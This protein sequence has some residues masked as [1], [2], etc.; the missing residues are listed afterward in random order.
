MYINGFH[1]S[2][3]IFDHCFFVDFSVSSLL[4]MTLFTH[5]LALLILSHRSLRC[6]YFKFFKSFPM[7]FS[8]DFYQSASGFIA[9]SYTIY[10]LLRTTSEFFMSYIELEFQF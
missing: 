1:Q 2:G 5:I 4:F 3:E 7:F 9:L 8:L 10:N 6:V